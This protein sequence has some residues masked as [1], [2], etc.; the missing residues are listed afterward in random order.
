MENRKLWQLFSALSAEETG[1]FDQWLEAELFQKQEYVR[2]LKDFLVREYP[3][4][5]EDTVAWSFLYP[6]KPYDD[7][8]FRK[9]S[10]DLTSHVE[11]FLAIKAFR[12]D[13][14][15]REFL[16][17]QELNRRKR[18]EV[19]IKM[20]RKIEKELKENP[21]RNA[22]YYRRLFE[23]ESE[24]IRFEFE[25][26]TQIDKFPLNIAG[27]EG[28]NMNQI[29]LHTYAFDSWWLHE[30]LS[31]LAVNLNNRQWQGEEAENILL[32]EIMKII[33]F[34]PVFHQ[35]N[36]LVIYQ[37]LFRI[38][39]GDHQGNLPR[40]IQILRKENIA[41]VRDDLLSVFGLMLNFYIRKLNTTG[42][43]A[44]AREIYTLYE[45]G[46]EDRLIFSNQYLPSVHFKNIITICLRT[47]DYDRA[48]DYLHKLRYLLPPEEQ[49]DVFTLRLAQLFV[50]QQKHQEVIR[51]L[52]N[53]KFMHVN[54]E[55]NARSF[56]LEAHY[57]INRMDTEWLLS[58]TE[59]LIRYIRK[60]QEI[61]AQPKQAYIN[62]FRLFRRLLNAY[63]KDELLQV[64]QAV[65]KADPIDR[66]KWLLDKISEKLV[67]TDKLR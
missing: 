50:H 67:R 56:L 51:T 11:E 3:N 64:E 19:F 7:A 43:T 26:R 52:S 31:L 49:E 34:H 66:P 22:R 61:G 47:E 27:F 41:E 57:E 1:Q 60:Q 6:D 44:I 16:L 46:I 12:N 42:E 13:S 24:K 37:E 36:W 58:Q 23:V 35:Q 15:T 39:R 28:E 18:P 29:Q 4:A 54:D 65:K 62:R 2:K 59:N 32:P 8:R 10:R 21:N 55:I 53:R 20:L 33:D 14:Q 63:T 9:L 45:W 48:W 17:L 38:L 30:K 25:H 40:M 5:P